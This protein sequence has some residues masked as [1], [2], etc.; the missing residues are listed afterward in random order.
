MKYLRIALPLV[1]GRGAGLGNE[2]I[3]WGKAFLAA[4]ALGL[5]VGH[6]AWGLNKRGYRHY[7]QTPK[8]DWLWHKTLT[9]GL[10]FYR[11]DDVERLKYRGSFEEAI[12]SFAD[13]VNLPKSGPV[14]IGLQGMG[15]GY[16]QL[17]PAREFLRSKLLTTRGALSNLYDIES[18]LS[19]N[20]LRIGLH[21]RLGDFQ[22]K[23]NNE[24]YQGRFNVT[25]PLQWYINVALSLKSAF[26]EQVE[27]IVV[28]DGSESELRA[29]TQLVPCQLTTHQT[30][31][32]IS[33]LLALA[34]CDFILCSISS[35]SLWG[36][37]LSQAGFGWFAPNLTAEA[38][39]GSIWGHEEA[40]RLPG[41]ATR[42]A[43]DKSI[44][45]GNPL[46]RGVAIAPN[47]VL[48]DELIDDLRRR[49]TLKQSHSNILLYG[50]TNL[51]K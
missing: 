2:L 51:P 15:G 43:L 18:R 50:V 21:V 38:G 40:Q 32:D 9:K 28:S 12:R 25:I 17:E 44:A 19:P 47:G 5:E 29:L 49:F 24:D 34:S 22:Q 16:E 39:F 26:G 1:E 45:S 23:K 27:F 41:S 31:R 11:F 46:G 8:L 48:P 10:P 14:V 37:F 13:A 20:K 6:P 42:V 36:A 35:Y 33:D 30:H 4:Q 3:V 7:F